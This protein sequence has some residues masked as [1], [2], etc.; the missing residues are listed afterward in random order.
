MEYRDISQNHGSITPLLQYPDTPTLQ[1]SGSKKGEDSNPRRYIWF[2]LPPIPLLAS[3]LFV[4]PS[5]QVSWRHVAQWFSEG[6]ILG[7]GR[8]G[9]FPGGSHPTRYPPAAGDP[10]LPGRGLPDGFRQ[11]PS[12]PVPQSSGLPGHPRALLG[13]GL[14]RGPGPH[15]GASPFREAPFSSACWP[16]G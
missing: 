3:S 9:G 14:R 11:Y 10:D 1:Y 13:G 16:W 12:S 7:V 4:G 15:P 2:Y 6:R 5:D 8:I